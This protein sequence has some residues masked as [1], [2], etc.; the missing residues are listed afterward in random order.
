M[1]TT[2]RETTMPT[3]TPIDR[4]SKPVDSVQFRASELMR[5]WLKAEADRRGRGYSPLIREALILWAEKHGRPVP[6]PR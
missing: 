3:A 1:T 6:P 5:R 2:Q 4:D